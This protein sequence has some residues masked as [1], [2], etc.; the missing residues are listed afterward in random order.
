MEEVATRWNPSLACPCSKNKDS[1]Q[2]LGAEKKPVVINRI[3]SSIKAQ[4]G[5][6]WKQVPT[7]I[8]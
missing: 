3:Q 5:K 8:K 1:N 6:P 7:G 2:S 4:E